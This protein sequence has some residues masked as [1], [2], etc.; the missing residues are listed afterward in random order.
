MPYSILEIGFRPQDKVIYA[1]YM[2]SFLQ[3]PIDNM[4]ANKACRTCYDCV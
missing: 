4:A 3:Q 1:N 2:D